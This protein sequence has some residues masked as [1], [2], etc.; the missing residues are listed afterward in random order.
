[1]RAGKDPA[2]DATETGAREGHRHAKQR[3]SEVAAVLDA[4]LAELDGADAVQRWRAAGTRFAQAEGPVD[5]RVDT[6]IHLAEIT[7]DRVRPETPWTRLSAMRW[8]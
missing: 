2:H 8:Q 7:S 6:L 1:M 5:W 3:D 4:T